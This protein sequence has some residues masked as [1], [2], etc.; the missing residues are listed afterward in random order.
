MKPGSK[1]LS[2][3]APSSR[4]LLASLDAAAPPPTAALAAHEPHPVLVDLRTP[5]LTH[6]ASYDPAELVALSTK[7]NARLVSHASSG[8]AGS[9]ALL[10]GDAGGESRWTR[11]RARLFSYKGQMTL[12][13]CFSYMLLGLVMAAVGP[14]LSMLAVNTASSVSDLAFVFP[15]RSFGYFLG[16]LLGGPLFDS[17]DGCTLLCLALSLC[18]CATFLIPFASY[19]WI[20]VLLICVQGFSLGCLDTGGNVLL[21]WVHGDKVAPF[22]QTMHFSFGLGAVMAPLTIERFTQG[23]SAGMLKWAFWLMALLFIPIAIW[24]M[25]LPGPKR[26]PNPTGEGSRPQQSNYSFTRYEFHIIALTATLL[27]LYVGCEIAYGG[28]IF[29]YA[30]EY[31]PIDMDDSS[32][33]FLTAVFWACLAVGRLVAIPISLYVTPAQML[34]WDYV[35]CFCGSL[36]MVLFPYSQLALWSCTAVYGFFMASVFPTIM[37][38]T[39]GYMVV[40]GSAASIFV[41]GASLGE[42]LI[43]II[44]AIIFTGGPSLFPALMWAIFLANIVSVFVFSV[45]LFVGRPGR[46]GDDDAAEGEGFVYPA[47]QMYQTWMQSKPGGEYGSTGTT[48]AVVDEEDVYFATA[49][50]PTL[51]PAGSPSA[52]QRKESSQPPNV[53]TALLG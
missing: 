51:Q 24:L 33:D 14:A 6:T 10:E 39:E 36:M 43:P 47:A 31:L 2:S 30:T 32:A 13:L 5:A 53:T 34:W 12:T 45:I 29:V 25:T 22:M 35:G 52:S 21:M 19:L 50:P 17:Y 49:P 4:N 40:T 15:V 9:N 48:T 3:R 42:A 46:Q 38:L 11:Y 44:L 20:V 37:N 28:Y 1:L 41:V 7:E 16:S 26:P 23:S 27:G 8:S 18:G